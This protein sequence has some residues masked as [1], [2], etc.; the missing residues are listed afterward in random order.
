VVAEVADIRLMPEAV[1]AATNADA[2]VLA[3]EWPQFLSFDLAALR[4]VMRGDFFFDGRNNFDPELVRRAGFRYVGIGRRPAAPSSPSMVLRSDAL[5]A[6][7]PV[8]VGGDLEA[9]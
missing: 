2:I 7:D 3:T 8:A 6:P 9:G 1:R 4:R 5:A